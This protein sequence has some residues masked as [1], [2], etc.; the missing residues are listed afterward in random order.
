MDKFTMIDG[1]MGSV[2]MQY[3]GKEN[4]YV[5]NIK[6]S[7]VVK[8]LH[9]DYIKSGSK[10]ICANTFSANSLVIKPDSEYST[11]E[12]IAKGVQIALDAAK[13]GKEIKVALDIGPL[14][15]LLE[16]YGDLEEDECEKIYEEIITT[17]VNAGAQIIFF[18]TFIDLEML[19]IAVKKAKAIAPNLPV[20]CSMSFTPVGKTIMG[21]SVQDMIEELVPFGID[22][23]GLNCSMEPKQSLPIAKMF[24]EHTN[25]PIIF[26]PNAGVPNMTQQ[27]IVYEEPEIFTNE[28]LPIAEIEGEFYIGGCCGTTPQHIAN[29]KD[30]L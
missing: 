30:K 14:T 20:F 19:K 7:E 21:Q 10:I 1:A 25:L 22:A 27:G 4:V 15:E 13:C 2:L 28:V 23:I 12:I 11:S 3:S 5:C 29:L 16:P 18:E 6:N 17:G 24:K 26:K 8:K 9:C